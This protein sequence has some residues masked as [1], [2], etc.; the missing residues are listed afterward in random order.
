MKKTKKGLMML[1]LMFV[2]VLTTITPIHGYNDFFEKY[3]SYGYTGIQRK[4]YVSNVGRNVDAKERV[5][6]FYNDGSWLYCIENGQHT[7]KDTSYSKASSIDEF[8]EKTIH[9]KTTIAQ[10]KKWLGILLAMAPRSF[11][12]SVLDQGKETYLR[13][14]ASATLVWEIMDECRDANFKYIGAD[15]GKTAPR[16]GNIYTTDSIRQEFFKY[17]DEYVKRI[18]DFNKIP[19]FANVSQT[20][21][22]VYEMT[23]NKQTQQY[24]VIL[25]DQNK[26]LDHY[27]I[28]GDGCQFERN[29]NVLKIVTKQKLQPQQKIQVS[30]IDGQQHRTTALVGFE[31]ANSSYQKLMCAGSLE[32]PKTR[33]YFQLK[34]S[35]GNLELKKTDTVSSLIDGAIFH[36]TNHSDFNQD[37]EVKNGK[38]IVENL[39]PGVYQLQEIKA[40]HGYVLDSTL[41]T[42]VIE[43]GQTTQKVIVNKEP[44]GTIELVKSINSDKTN[45]LCGDAFV[46]GTTY[47]LY[48]KEDIYNAS[49]THQFYQ[50]NQCISEKETDQNGKIVF[51]QLPLGKYYLKELK[52]N[53]SL[54]IDSRII[55][56]ELKYKDM[57]QKVIVQKVDV[58]DVIASQRI[59]IFKQG[60]KDGESGIV[61][62]LKGAEFTFVLNK[63]YEDV[64]F[65]KAKKYFVGVTDENG[66]VT[67]SLLPYGI[68]RVRETKTPEGYYG[69]SDFLVEV[70][71]DGSLYEIGYEM[72][73]VTVNNMPFESLLK[74]VK[75][76]EDS[77]KIVNIAGATFKIKN[78][79]TQEYVS[80]IDW[81]AFPQIHV[82]QW[83][84][85]D[86]GTIVL[87]TKLKPGKYVLEEIK[88]PDGYILNQK[89]LEFEI[90]SSHYDISEDGSTP[91]TVVRFKDKAVKGQVHIEKVGDVL[92]GFQDGRFVYEKRGLKD[93]EYIIYAKEDILDPSKDKSVLYHEGDQVCELKTDEDGK[94]SSPLLPLGKYECREVK[95]NY[96][97]VLDQKSYEFELSYENQDIELVEKNLF[98][99]NERQKVVVQAMKKDKNNQD[100]L[101]GAQFSLIANMDIMNTNGECIV[102]KDTILQTVQSSKDGYVT[103]DID[104]PILNENQTGNLY[105]IEEI[106]AP[107]GYVLENLSYDIPANYTGEKTTLYQYIFLNQ[108]TKVEIDKV[109]KETSLLLEGAKLQVIDPIT[110]KVVDEWISHGDSHMIEGLF[111][112]KE[113]ILHEVFAPDGYEISPDITFVVMNQINP[114]KVIFENEKSLEKK[115]LGVVKTDDQTMLEGYIFVGI[116]SYIMINVLFKKKNNE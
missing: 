85:H 66:F 71:K 34:M 100:I 105:R 22:P 24:E 63:E 60:V 50:K 56:V 110:H 80:Y 9:K 90:N 94:V 102:K 53:D 19:S 99:E 84:T 7:S 106:K 59:Q 57:N 70:E 58:S 67:T 61:H 21:Q 93:I 72:K 92:V 17:Y 45:Y 111:V 114:Q 32:T 103:F 23:Y 14:V 54:L 65:E 37:V 47:G 16:D 51:D 5:T 33:A 49:K 96:G 62:G 48:A 18:L 109:D 38:I 10:K 79:E 108:K 107:N 2:M 11:S 81:S 101:D 42:V 13:Y 86:D 88:A 28:Q 55:D 4:S 39:T 69:T 15:S 46:S 29:G 25:E 3:T 115:I 112:D 12:G 87:N 75:M 52:T 43:S 95:T 74:I 116:V 68:Y 36:L 30:L 26:I 8:L 113:Y 76:D 44:S 31:P 73:K 98:M 78:L 64:G 27:Q 35:Y 83:T 104:L 97:Y 41:Y 6:C 1:V 20:Q 40:P 82:D 89:L 77:E 91:I